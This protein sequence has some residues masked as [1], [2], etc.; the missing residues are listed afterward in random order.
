MASLPPI[1]RISKEDLPEAPEWIDKV[2]Y[3][4]NLFFDSVYRALNGRLTSPENI[5]GQV[6]EMRF[7]VIPTYDG[8]DT[9]K[10]DIQKFQSTLG[11]LAKSL[12]LMQI[13][14]VADNGNFVPIANDIF[15]DWEDENRI[16]K[17]HYITGLT[18]S[19]KYL[20]RVKIE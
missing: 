11:G 3:P 1:K 4:I 16:I 8:T 14:E 9:D 2:I 12:Q 5:V 15:I 10:W 18:A 13:T 6:K 7:Q 20:L 17:I 19:K